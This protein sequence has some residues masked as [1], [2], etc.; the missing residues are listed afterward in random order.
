VYAVRLSPERGSA[1][2]PDVVPSRWL[3]LG[4]RAA[5]SIL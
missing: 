3:A 2:P 1:A 5:C 4:E